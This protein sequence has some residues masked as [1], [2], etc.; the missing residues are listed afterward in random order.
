MSRIPLIRRERLALAAA[1]IR[2]ALAGAVCAAINWLL[3]HI[4]G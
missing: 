4:G 2:G 3:D 1:A